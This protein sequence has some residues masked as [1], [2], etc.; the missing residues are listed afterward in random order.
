MSNDDWNR[1]RQ[2][3]RDYLASPDFHRFNKDAFA[4]LFVR[5]VREDA[6]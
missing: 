5:I 6:S 1:Y 4:D 2:A 3:A